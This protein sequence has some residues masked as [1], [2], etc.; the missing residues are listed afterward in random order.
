MD[1]QGDFSLEVSGGGRYAPTTM[2]VR[3]RKLLVL[4]ALA[5]LAPA[6][7]AGCGSNDNSANPPGG[8][9]SLD[10]DEFQLAFS[11]LGDPSPAHYEIWFVI[12][13]IARSGGKFR[14]DA[15]GRIVDL[16]GGVIDDAILRAPAGVV[17][18]A[19]TRVFVSLEPDN[20]AD[21]QPSGSRL[22]GGALSAG[23]AALSV[24]DVS[25]LNVSFSGATGSF[26][27][28]TP[29]TASPTDFNRGIAWVDMPSLPPGEPSV[30][31]GLALPALP[32]GWTYEGWIRRPTA[33]GPINY[34]IGR[35]ATA[36]GFDSDR[37][38]STAGSF[39]DDANGDGRGDGFAFPAQDFVDSS[40]NI[41]PLLLDD[42]GFG[43]FLSVEPN[44]DISASPFFIQP[45]DAEIPPGTSRV[46][47]AL[48]GF[49][50]IGA[51]HFE[52][53][54]LRVGVGT[55]S[56]GKFRVDASGQTLDLSGNPID[57][58]D[59]PGD[60]LL[61]TRIFVT[62][63]AAGDN[64][65]IPSRSRMIDGALIDSTATLS[66]DSILTNRNTFSNP[67]FR[68]V[69]FLNTFT[70]P[71]S[72]GFARGVWFFR[73]STAADDPD[74]NG[75][76]LPIL[77]NGWSFEAWVHDASSGDDYSTGRFVSPG[78]A[79]NDRAGATADTFGV[80]LDRNGHADGPRYPGQ[81]FILPSPSAP[82]PLDLDNGNF[83][84]FL[85]VEPNPDPDSAPFLVR[86]FE[87]GRID[88]LGPRQVI[89]LERNPE[90]VPS[91]T[92]L[93]SRGPALRAMT[94]RSSTLP[95]GTV[96]VGGN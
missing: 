37:A 2:T 48:S 79:D 24:G 73:P 78:A 40:G 9:R 5:S 96:T 27:L 51:G 68:G 87:N 77:H 10:R 15:S 53:W 94:N 92:V 95:S 54:A 38:G 16:A 29:T 72:A 33:S 61:S 65:T 59:V 35:F 91:A 70:N 52:A 4:V 34:S 82:A 62:V 1:G 42:G 50:P 83:A 17:L 22:V 18:A 84:V 7:L 32:P 66:A 12:D 57:A 86:V 45:L 44:P 36:T 23:S 55:R 13:G 43:A 11:G 28:D 93:I 60:L 71:D 41:P 25:G 90:P 58:F 81:E 63:E 21:P 80:D 47:F 46:A 85:T 19:A 75:F 6:L 8:G 67:A 69:Y 31:P 26:V 88:S 49:G 89:A 76:V 20:D 3:T 30:G 39:G 14:V 74:S 56:I 64:D